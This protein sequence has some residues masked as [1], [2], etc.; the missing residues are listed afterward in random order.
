MFVSASGEFNPAAAGRQATGHAALAN[1][2]VSATRSLG[3]VKRAFSQMKPTAV[4]AEMF[5]ASR[6]L[7]SDA[8]SVIVG[9]IRG[10]ALNDPETMCI[11][12][13]LFL[14]RDVS[15]ALCIETDAQ[16]ASGDPEWNKTH[17]LLREYLIHTGGPQRLLENDRAALLG[18]SILEDHLVYLTVYDTFAALT[19]N[20]EPLMLAPGHT[21]WIEDVTCAQQ[22]VHADFG[23]SLKIL[24]TVAQ[25]A[26]LLAHKPYGTPGSIASDAESDG[27]Y[28]R[29]CRA[30][31]E[32]L[33]TDTL[34]TIY[35]TTAPTRVQ[36]GDLLIRHALICHLRRIALGR[37][38]DDERIQASAAAIVELLVE[39]SVRTGSM[40][41]LNYPIIVAAGL[42]PPE[43]RERMQTIIDFVR[44]TSCL[45][46]VYRM[47]EVSSLWF[48]RN[49]LTKPDCARLLAA[50][51]ERRGRP[52]DGHLERELTYAYSVVHLVVTSLAHHWVNG[53]THTE[54]PLA[55]CRVADAWH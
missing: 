25:L 53:S 48:T 30:L 1:A 29:A 33:E 4:H 26:T 50:D 7:A 14:M 22:V 39:V 43:E 36:F 37:S 40:I 9:A 45:Q 11:L 34:A 8:A 32:E 23:F 10:T 12:F 44:L 47:E 42:I 28:V 52:H 13:E 27:A 15:D 16:C 17:Q 20:V 31:N 51:G 35:S 24:S 2:L 5:A 55:G 49:L 19:T 38:R 41:N 21:R 54:A 6:Q 46:E 18:N 3:A